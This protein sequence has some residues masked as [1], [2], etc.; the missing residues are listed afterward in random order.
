MNAARVQ[1]C[2]AILGFLG[3]LLGAFGAH[4][5]N[6]R[7]V[8]SGRVDTWETAVFYHLIHALVLLSVSRMPSPPKWSVNLFLIGVVIFSGSL[9]AL[10][11]TD[12]T[13]LGAITP[14]GGLALMAGWLTLCWPQ[15]NH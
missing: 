2:A 11:L 4:A 6:E 12:I 13:K 9:Y 14:I 7:L 3:V 15:K 8:E 1:Q 5:L 10:C